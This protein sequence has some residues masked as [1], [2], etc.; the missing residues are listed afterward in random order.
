MTVIKSMSRACVS[1][2]LAFLIANYTIVLHYSV[3][4]MTEHQWYNFNRAI[5]WWKCMVE[6]DQRNQFHR[7]RNQLTMTQNN[8]YEIY[9]LTK[10]SHSTAS[11][12]CISR[13]KTHLEL[14]D[15]FQPKKIEIP[16]YHMHMTFSCAILGVLTFDCIFLAQWVHWHDP[17]NVRFS[18]NLLH[19][20]NISNVLWF[21]VPTPTSLPH[22]ANKN[23]KFNIS[24]GKSSNLT[25]DINLRDK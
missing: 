22:Q 23:G 3:Q 7:K 24:R 21:V 9:S 8:L 11:F 18:N 15:W 17:Q 16:V 25:R 14:K 19:V 13:S 1:E 4:N 10:Y 2:N 12:A 6:E 20:W 5:E